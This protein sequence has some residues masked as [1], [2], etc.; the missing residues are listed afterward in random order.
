MSI[1]LLKKLVKHEIKRFYV[2]NGVNR[3]NVVFLSSG[4]SEFNICS[5]DEMYFC[6][7]IHGK[8]FSVKVNENIEAKKLNYLALLFQIKELLEDF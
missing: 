1:K 7:K 5:C 3:K 8:L 6:K 2:K 4:E